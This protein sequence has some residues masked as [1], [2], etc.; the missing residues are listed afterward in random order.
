MPRERDRAHMGKSPTARF[1]RETKSSFE[2]FDFWLEKISLSKSEDSNRY[3]SPCEAAF[4]FFAINFPVGMVYSNTYEDKFN[5]YFIRKYTLFNK[6]KHW[7]SEYHNI[8]VSNNVFAARYNY[9]ESEPVSG[10]ENPRSHD[11][12]APRYRLKDE[13]D[14]LSPGEAS[15]SLSYRSHLSNYHKIRDIIG[16]YLEKSDRRIQGGVCRAV[17]H[18]TAPDDAKYHGVQ[19]FITQI[20]NQQE[21]G[22]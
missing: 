7:T 3:L 19:I 2:H 22:G 16:A 1:G 21:P 14:I 10:V 15:E 17:T 9:Y 20:A 18:I 4:A 13:N 12:E 11:C 6:C 8:D 5:E